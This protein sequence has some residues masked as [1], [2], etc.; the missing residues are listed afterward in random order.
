MKKKLFDLS[1]IFIGYV[2]CIY[3]MVLTWNL[4]IDSNIFLRLLA[5]HVEATIFI[6]ILSVAFKNSSWYDAFWSV[7][8][9]V[10]T[11]LCWIDIHSAGNVLRAG[12][13]FDVMVFWAIRLTYNWA[14]SWDGFTHE[15]W[16][17]VMM[18]R[19][20]NNK[21]QYF[22]IDFG[23]IHLIPTLSVFMALLPMNYTLYYP[24]PE[25][26]WLDWVAYAIGISAVF[27]QIVSDQQMYNFRKSLTEPQTM[28][29]GLWFY[30][31]HPNYLGEILFWFSFFIF[32]LS[33][34]FT[35]AWLILGTVTMYALVAI[36]SVAMMDKRSLERRLDFKDYMASTPAIFFNFF[37]R[38]S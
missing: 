23:A 20:A 19:K 26:F 13:M 18:K 6:Y 21:I 32:S 7:I 10:L 9:V 12:M 36:T 11:V 8:P 38:K 37:K 34:G 24:G 1:I 15:D 35:A 29:S 3:S 17:Y 16:R 4:L 30:S 14:R 5:C 31:R 25:V 28:Q 33:N 2:A 22:L 27:I